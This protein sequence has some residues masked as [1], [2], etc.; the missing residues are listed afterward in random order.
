MQFWQ[1]IWS[2][3]FAILSNFSYEIISQLSAKI[4][5]LDENDELNLDE[6]DAPYPKPLSSTVKKSILMIFIAFSG[7]HAN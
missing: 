4:G 6:Q 1:N 7:R 5:I 2:I 3:T